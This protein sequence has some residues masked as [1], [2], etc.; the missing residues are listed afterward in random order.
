ME[1]IFNEDTVNFFEEKNNEDAKRNF[2][3]VFL[4]NYVVKFINFHRMMTEKKGR[5]PFII[6]NTDRSD[7][8]GT[9]WWSFLDLHLKKE[10]FLFVR[11]G[12]E[13]F[14]QF[15]MQDDRK[16]LNKILPGIEKFKKNDSEVTLITLKF[17]M[18]A[19]N[20]IKNAHNLSTTTIDFLH[21]M[22]EYGK[23]SK[24]KDEIKVHLVDD[25]LQKLDTDTC[26]IFQLYFYVNL[27]APMEGSSI[28][29]DKTLSKSTTEKLLN[30]IFT[31][32]RE[33]N[34]KKIEQLAEEEDKRKN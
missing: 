11:F 2:V 22:S 1:G 24:I 3:G 20:E 31:L 32:D 19:Y 14:K 13:G 6:I 9:H 25:Q 16:I 33:S 4:S 5:Y 34:E 26:G 27:F 28:I 30:E 17:S 10:I 7:K 15:I 8:G 12:F 21:L 18:A 23:L 29:K